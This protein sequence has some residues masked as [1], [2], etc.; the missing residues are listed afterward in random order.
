MKKVLV[1]LLVFVI[2]LFGFLNLGATVNAS[3]NDLTEEGTYS[4][5]VL[6]EQNRDTQFFYYFYLEDCPVCGD[7]EVWFEEE[8]MPKFP[9]LEMKKINVGPGHVEN[10]EFFISLSKENFGITP[11]E[12]LGG[13]P[14]VFIGNYYLVGFPGPREEEYIKRL[15]GDCLEYGCI[16][17]TETTKEEARNIRGLDY[18]TLPLL[19]EVNIREAGFPLFTIMVAAMDGLNPCALWILLFLLAY[20]I[21]EKSRKKM[22]LVAGTFILTSAVFYFFLL[23]AWL[24]VF[25]LFVY[26]R[27][28]KIGIGLLALIVGFLQLQS[29]FKKEQGCPTSTRDSKRFKKIN[30]RIKTIFAT[31]SLK[32]IIPGTIILALSVNLFGFF[33]SAGFPAIFTGVMALQGFPRYI[34]LLFIG[35]YAFIFMLDEV[36][37]FT[38]AFVTLRTITAGEK[39]AK[40]IGLIGGLLMILLGTL[41]IFFPEYLI[42]F[43][44]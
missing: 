38:V 15:V 25:K 21:K 13:V 24:E 19:G 33:C 43:S 42:I 32:V 39:V 20:A 29:F 37:I 10:R 34:E 31:N 26:V 27:P 4:S 11:A 23:A 3:S 16:S 6:T 12:R 22:V 30:E 8:L 5:L 7:I 28:L 41:L 2:G 14:A 9:E 18:I 35:L 40:W 44:P 17:P 1:L 36:I